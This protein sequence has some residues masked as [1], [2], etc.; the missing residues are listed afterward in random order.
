MFDARAKA[1]HSYRITRLLRRSSRLWGEHTFA[2]A[3]AGSLMPTI[4]LK[5]LKPEPGRPLYESAKDALR[6]A[7][8]AGVFAPG[9]QMPN[10]KQISEQLGVSL[11]TAHRALQEL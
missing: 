3:V 1:R 8:D 11:V 4:K 7:I 10:T 6:G 2:M 5:A 9:Q